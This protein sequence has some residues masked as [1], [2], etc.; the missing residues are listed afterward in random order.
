MTASELVILLLLTYAAA[1]LAIG[2]AARK[3]INSFRDTIAAPGQATFLLLAGSAIAGQIG[4]GFVVGGAEYGALYGLGG[5]W[6]GIGCGLSYIAV[7]FLCKFIFK[8]KFVSLAD[9]FS[10]R[11]QGKKIRLIYSIATMFSCVAMLSGQLLAGRAVFLTLGLPAAWGVVLTAVISLLYSNVAGLWGSMAVSTVQTGIIFLGMVSAACAMLSEP[12]TGF[13][14]QSLPA[15][16]F[17]PVPFDREFLISILAPIVLAAPVNQL[18]FQHTVSAKSAKTAQF[19]YLCAGLFLIPVALIPPLLGLFGRTLFPVLPASEVFTSLLLYRLP[20]PV[21]AVILA[22]V[23]C[24]VITSC[25]GAYIAVATSFVHDLYQGIIARQGDNRTYRFLMLAVDGIVCLV[26]I[27]LALWMD[28]IIQLLSMG[29]SLLAAGC[30]VPFLGGIV[31]KGG[32]GTG[33]LA[34]AGVGMAASLASSLGLIQLPY[35]SITSV[36]LSLVA[37]VVCS[38][39]TAKKTRQYL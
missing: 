6:Y 2:H 19:G 33:A 5:A 28:D 34:G 20:T 29:Y 9:Y 3:R 22:A 10:L 1:M 18:V 35:A 32:T 15:S 7:S 14:I 8:R 4:S 36:L 11:Y 39:L 16:C 30:L 13:L 26:G 37:Y 21:A 23:V 25:N 12:G 27:F 38:L 24:A 17:D 31:W